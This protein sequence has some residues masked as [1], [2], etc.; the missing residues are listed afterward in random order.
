MHRDDLEEL[1]YITPIN[2][3]PSIMRH[4]ILSNKRADRLEHETVALWEVQERRENK[5]LPTG[6]WL[7]DYVNLY[8]CARN[9]MMYKRRN[10][11]H[12]LCV[13]RI[14]PEVLDIRGA[15]ITDQN[16][17]SNYAAFYPS[18]EGLRKVNEDLVFSKYWTHPDQI[19]A[20]RHKS[21]K[22]AEVLIPD[23]V[24]PVCII[25]AYSSCEQ[26]IN[27]L[28]QYGLTGNIVINKHMFFL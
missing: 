1:H 22:C 13:L 3:I 12:D 9:P 5:R 26:S 15:V 27:R 11:H 4:G 20:W 28:L 6:K 14:S 16:A 10:L 17:S 19:K 2:N 18:P 21:I 7:H 8:I 23:R 24:D 25:G